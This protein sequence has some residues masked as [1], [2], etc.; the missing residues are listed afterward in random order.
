MSMPGRGCVV[1]TLRVDGRLE[2]DL[3][4]LLLVV[5][6]LVDLLLAGELFRPLLVVLRELLVRPDDVPPRVVFLAGLRLVLSFLRVGVLRP[7][8]LV[9]LP[10]LLGRRDDAPSPVV[11]LAGLRLVLSLLRVVVFFSAI[12]QMFTL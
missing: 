4:E 8:L 11:F 2:V 6:V 12:A 1:L 9:V 5:V 3:R 7:L 10:E